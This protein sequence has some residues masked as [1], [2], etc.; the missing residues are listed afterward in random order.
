MSIINLKKQ[1]YRFLTYLVIRRLSRKD[2]DPCLLGIDGERLRDLDRDREYDRE[3]ER[4]PY[5]L[6][7]DLDLDLL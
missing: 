5:P 1:F 4:L 3:Q 2:G 7:R 6:E